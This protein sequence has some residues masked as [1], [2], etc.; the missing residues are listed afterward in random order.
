M[1]RLAP[2]AFASSLSL[3]CLA[4]GACGGPDGAGLRPE[5]GSGGGAG[6]AP[7]GGAGGAARP[8][9][10]AG[11]GGSGGGGARQ[12][13]GGGAPGE[14]PGTGQPTPNGV[15]QSA[16]VFDETKLATYTFT[17]TAADLQKMKATAIQELY[18]PAELSVD[19]QAVGKVG[20][21]YKGAWGTLRP[22]FEGGQTCPKVSLKVDFAEY[23]KEKKW[24]GLKKLN[25]HALM[26][27]TSHLH[28][29]LAYKVW[30][31][32]GIHT[33]RST[34]AR[35]VVNGEPQGVFALT[36]Q[37]DGRFT[38][39]RWPKAGD[40][41][42][43]KE[44]WP[45][46][47]DAGY[48]MTRLETNEDKNPSHAKIVAFAQALTKAAT[49]AAAAQVLD[50]W[51]GID[52][53]MRYLAVDRAVS[54]W[55]GAT[56]FYC[57]GAG[58]CTNH[59]FY[60]YQAE[61]EDRLTLIPWDHDNTGTVGTLFDHVPPWDK[62]PASCTERFFAGGNQVT[63]PGCDPIFRALATQRPAY[64]A[65]VKKLL[66][67]WS[68]PRLH[69]DLDRWAAV[70]EPAIAVD[71]NGPGLEAWK[72]AVKGFKYEV[73]VVRERL[74]ALAAG[75]E[76]V[77]VGLRAGV[78][79]DFEGSRLGL[80]QA[81]VAQATFGLAHAINTTAP[82]AGAADVRLDFAAKGT[83]GQWGWYRMSMDKPVVSLA[84]LK[85]VKIRLRADQKRYVRIDLDSPK[86]KNY[87]S[88]VR[89]GWEVNA[90]ETPTQFTLDASMLKLPSW[91]MAQGDV[92]AQI[93]A[94]VSGLIVSG[95]VKQNMPDGGWVQIDD[96]ELV[97]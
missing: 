11:A 29:R 76:V 37:I 24:N 79:N 86:Y 10:A 40:G 71:G 3:A 4:L 19:G 48:Y 6:L 34:H 63:S 70:L 17:L 73:G 81:M 7:R 82:I 62:P 46:A 14:A 13:G 38:S 59:N 26:R 42:L 95:L 33:C 89:F 47:A 45:T 91:G 80:M 20:L 68:V 16:A 56:T 22:C 96:V 51:F 97:M 27:D 31:E 5:D 28:E 15:P 75:K 87:W 57:G 85:A 88:G 8:A 61:A 84:G 25:F 9:D 78:V 36:E 39:D 2:I 54:N 74:E 18:V 1:S 52:H 60:V 72:V 90:T 65:A 41:N 12:D 43:Y 94:E 67:V 93:L 23:D 92:V 30:R 83:K 58:P 21:R 77:P 55:D 44:A 50:K 49:P 69:A 35:I 32:M 66:D 64:V 53:L